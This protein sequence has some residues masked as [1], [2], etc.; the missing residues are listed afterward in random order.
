M[1]N[2]FQSIDRIATNLGNTVIQYRYLVIL[3]S[4][5]VTIAVGT[6]STKLGFSTDYRDFFSDANPELAAFEALQEVYSK[7]DNITIMVTPIEQGRDLFSNDVLRAVDFITQESWQIPYTQRVD[8]ITNFQYTYADGD[9]LIVEDLVEFSGN[10]PTRS[11]NEIREIVLA[12]PLLYKQLVDES[13]SA[14]VI[15]VT[16]NLPNLSPFEVPEAVA[17]ARTI[18]DTVRKEFPNVDVRL[19]GVSMLNN[20]FSEAG[21][22]DMTS[23]VPL[24]FMIILA[25]TLL[26]TRS[27]TGTFATLLVIMFSSVVAIGFGGFIGVKLTPI[28]AQAPTIILTLAIADS[29][30]ILMTLRS[31]MRKGWDK[32]KAIIE[33]LRLNLLPVGITSLTTIVGFLALNFSDSP[34]FWHLGNMT[35][36]GILAAFIFSVTLL[37][38]TLAVLPIRIKAHTSNNSTAADQGTDVSDARFAQAFAK[39]VIVNAKWLGPVSLAVS[40][41]LIMF[42]PRIELNDQWT[43]Y[44]S[45]A[46]EFRSDTDRVVEKFGIYPIEFSLPSKGAGQISGPEY[47]TALDKFARYLEEPTIVAHV[48]SASDILKRLNKNLNNDDPQFYAI[49]ESKELGAQYLLLYEMSLPYG[50]DLNDRINIDKSATRVTALL[51]DTSTA[52]TKAFLA[53][54]KAWIRA[55][56]PAYMHNVQPTS[57]QVMFTYIAERNVHNMVIGT[58][59]AVLAISLILAFALLNWKLGLLSLVPNALPILTTFGVWALIVG[60]VGF[61]VAAVASISLG[62]IVDDTVHF[63][64]KYNRARNEKTYAPK[65]AIID[66]FEQV[67]LPIVVN[68]I[69]LA[70]G[71]LVLTFSMFKVNVDMGMLTAISIVFA[72][73]L[74][75]ILLP[76]LLLFFDK[77]KLV[78]GT[79]TAQVSA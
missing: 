69:I 15:N 16:S 26:I 53:E 60:E 5:I 21:F 7:N 62:I 37:P 52:Q 25:L 55:N 63:L 64:S 59:I 27:L 31:L 36:I 19:S 58:T 6:G 72:L 18:R 76:A 74:D 73:I 30:H 77:D 47:Q 75:F 65:A 46:I 32:N 8:S 29:I 35:A 51:S 61:S 40:I 39:W 34:P 11:S 28:S 22:N 10:T 41:G 24:M 42:I 14:T 68:T 2:Y 54:T 48:Y 44:F 13:V 1:N 56:L 57:A 3:L 70:T 17:Y 9:E 49:P 66:A 67:A 12:E 78:A 23:L 79:T 71:F 38:A 50:L 45:D 33:S 20:A 43:A 4:I